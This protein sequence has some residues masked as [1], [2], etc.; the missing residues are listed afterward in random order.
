MPVCG[1]GAIVW[2]LSLLCSTH[3]GRFQAETPLIPLFKFSEP[4]LSSSELVSWTSVRLFT[5]KHGAIRPQLRYKSRAMFARAVILPQ[6]PVQRAQQNW[7]GAMDT[8]VVELP[9]S[10]RKSRSAQ[11]GSHST[12]NQTEPGAVTDMQVP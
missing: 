1:S 10:K 7:R 12:Q 2:S 3:T 11:G 4:A 5:C 8:S 9:K 6:R